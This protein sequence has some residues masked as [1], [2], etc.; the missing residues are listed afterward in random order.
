MS[1]RG[2]ENNNGISELRVAA[3]RGDLSRV[4]ALLRARRTSLEG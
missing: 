3:S 4:E 2:N 1:A